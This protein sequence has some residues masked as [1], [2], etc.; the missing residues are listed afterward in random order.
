MRG[1]PLSKDLVRCM[2]RA[3]QYHI[4]D[5]RVVRASNMRGE[6][7]RVHP[8]TST[9]Y[10]DALAPETDRMRYVADALATLWDERVKRGY[11]R[12][13]ARRHLRLVDL[14]VN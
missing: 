3:V 10:Y 13:P 9:I 12:L 5:L 4:P 1:E 8:A 2:L 11:T 14:G 7:Y 6:P